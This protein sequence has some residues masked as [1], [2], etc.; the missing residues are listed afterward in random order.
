MIWNMMRMSKSCIGNPFW[1]EGR[2]EGARAR[3]GRAAV[4]LEG[5]AG[6]YRVA[7]GS[8]AGLLRAQTTDAA[9]RCTRVWSDPQMHRVH[10]VAPAALRCRDTVVTGSSSGQPQYGQQG[11]TVSSSQGIGIRFGS[12]AHP[13]A[14][15]AGIT[16]II[17]VRVPFVRATTLR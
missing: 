7:A 12:S 1:N 3:A 2:Q 17:E 10:T 13:P 9:P 6:C 11:M 14:L 5:S 15:D 4:L 8:A 16:L